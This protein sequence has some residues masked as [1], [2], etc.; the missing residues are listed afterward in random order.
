MGVEPF[1][2]GPNVCMVAFKQIPRPG[3][4]SAR[5][6]FGPDAHVVRVGLAE[7]ELFS[8]FDQALARVL[9]HRFQHGVA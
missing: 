9:T 4:W 1:E 5:Q 2:G 8:A 6:T 7:L 3:S